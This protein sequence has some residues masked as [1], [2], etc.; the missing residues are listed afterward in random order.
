MLTLTSVAQIFALVAVILNENVVAFSSLA[1]GRANGGIR[2]ST[3]QV[4]GQ[5]L[6]PV[7]RNG[8][9]FEDV[10][11]GQGRRILPGDTVACYYS[12]SFTKGPLG[13]P[14]IF[15]QITPDDG[16]PL[17]VVV[18][19]GETIRGWDLGILGGL[20]GEIPPMNVG[21]RRKLSIP[22][23]LAYGPNE[24]GPIP[25]NQDLDFELEVV[26]AGK[27]SDIS[28]KFRLGG[29]AIALGVPAII[30]LIAYT[31]LWH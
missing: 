28:L 12:G 10:V 11:I 31:L 3:G 29:Y 14:F 20:E 24:V 7:A 15:D 4:N 1:K 22:S 19:K 5:I 25:A 21:G 16:P 13:K 8:L 26:Q 2:T 27:E 23:G 18:G 30:L 17:K 9:A 6:G